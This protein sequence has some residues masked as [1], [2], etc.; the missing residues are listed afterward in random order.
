MFATGGATG[1]G[2][3]PYIRQRLVI[4]DAFRIDEA[5][6]SISEWMLQSSSLGHRPVI[7][8]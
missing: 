8:D 7:D 1:S 3:E 6:I 5:A 4:L 2:S